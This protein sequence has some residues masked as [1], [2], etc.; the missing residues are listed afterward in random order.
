MLPA[1]VGSTGFTLL[2]FAY[3]ALQILLAFNNDTSSG[4]YFVSD[5]NPNAIWGLYWYSLFILWGLS[6]GVAAL[7]FHKLRNMQNLD[8]ERKPAGA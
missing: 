6:L 8:M 7:C 4:Q 2:G 3:F 5:S 1:W